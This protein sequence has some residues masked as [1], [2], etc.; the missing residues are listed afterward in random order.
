MKF[1]N[2]KADMG[3]G[4]ILLIV[5]VIFALGWLINAGWKECKYNSECTENQYCGSDFA[6]HDMKVITKT[7]YSST[8]DYTPAAW[9]LGASLIISMLIFKS[10]T[11][12]KKKAPSMKYNAENIGQ[13]EGELE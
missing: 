7:E 5:I 9:I 8:V 10:D 6:C 12:F 2:K 11:I 4:V 1:R 13:Y 3:V